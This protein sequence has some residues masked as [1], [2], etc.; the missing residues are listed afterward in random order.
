MRTSIIICDVSQQ[1]CWWLC[2]FTTLTFAA[3][4]SGAFWTLL[5]LQCNGLHIKALSAMR[6]PRTPRRCWQQLHKAASF[7][8][9]P[10]PPDAFLLRAAAPGDGSPPQ[11]GCGPAGGNPVHSRFQSAQRPACTHVPGSLWAMQEIWCNDVPPASWEGILFPAYSRKPAGHCG[12]AGRPVP[13]L[14]KACRHGFFKQ[15]MAARIWFPLSKLK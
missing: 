12:V 14:R 15:R 1:L 10:A 9:W 7:P 11:Q 4:Y 5:T 2:W 6:R 3:T 13:V 8:W